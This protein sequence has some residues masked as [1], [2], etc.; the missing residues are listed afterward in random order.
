[1]RRGEPVNA[2][3]LLAAALSVFAIG[4]RFYSKLIAD[5]VLVLDPSRATPAVRNDGLDYVP[6]EKWIVYGHHFAA[7][8]GAG[9]WSGPCSPRR[10]VICRV[11]CGSCSASS[12]PVRCRTS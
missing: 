3:W 1:L 12:L 11:R 4:Y 6:T 9:P 10:W 7:I 8:A 2:I 5:K